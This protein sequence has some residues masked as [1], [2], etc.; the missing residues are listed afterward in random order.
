M[1][2]AE[3][4]PETR[5]MK[6]TVHVH[7]ASPRDHRHVHLIELALL[8]VILLV[9]AVTTLLKSAVVLVLTLLPDG[10][11]GYFLKNLRKPAAAR[12]LPTS[13]EQ[14]AQ[15]PAG[16]CP[17]VSPGKTTAITTPAPAAQPPAPAAPPAKPARV[18]KP[19]KRAPATAVTPDQPAAASRPARRR[20]SPTAA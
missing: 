5:K 15:L 19:A 11:A 6:S 17:E 18:R 7:T 14:P 20:R 12:D 1:A 13:M 8:A 2:G 4:T 16:V 9:E 3:W 10:A